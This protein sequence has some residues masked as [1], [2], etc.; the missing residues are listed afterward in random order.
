[1][2][3][4]V[5]GVNHKT[6]PVSLREKLSFGSDMGQAIGE[7]SQLVKGCTIVSTCNRSELY[8]GIDEDADVIDD[9]VDGEDMPL[10]AGMQAVG[11]WLAKF[12]KHL[13]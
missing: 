6:A 9:A 2:K 1:M 11:Q 4:A 10:S 8:F 5:I 7:L 12:K 3:L 13:I